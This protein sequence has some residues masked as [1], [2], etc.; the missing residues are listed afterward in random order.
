MT[1]PNRK[2]DG[3]QTLGDSL[4]TRPVVFVCGRTMGASVSPLVQLES[5]HVMPAGISLFVPYSCSG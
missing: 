4:L 3:S 2:G 5:R 1:V